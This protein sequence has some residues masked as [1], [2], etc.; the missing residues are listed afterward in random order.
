MSSSVPLPEVTQVLMT[1]PQHVWETENVIC[2]LG[3]EGD[4]CIVWNSTDNK[5]ESFMSIIQG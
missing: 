5:L 4:I 3:T 2:F 1:V